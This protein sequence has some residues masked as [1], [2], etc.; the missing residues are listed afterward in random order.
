MNTLKYIFKTS[1]VIL[2]LIC[3]NA[4]GAEQKTILI[5]KEK[6]GTDAKFAAEPVYTMEFRDADLKDVLRALG[7]EN[8]LNIIISEK[9]SGKVTLSFNK[10]K[11]MDAIDTILRVNNLTYN[12]E[13]NIMMIVASPF[14]EGEEGLVTKKIPVDFSNA[15]EVSES[16]KNMLSS[17]GKITI[18][19]RTNT[20]IVKDVAENV[21]RIS[22]L[23]KSLDTKTPQVMI[24]AR[25]V[26]ARSG[27]SRE[28][29]VQWGSDY[30]GN[31]T[32]RGRTTGNYLLSGGGT[33]ASSTDTTAT[34]LT[35][36][37]GI[38]GTGFL[39]NLPA[40]VGLGSGGAIGFSLV[41][42]NLGLDLQLS[43]MEITGKGKILSN[44]R[45]LTL[46]NKEA[47]ISSGRDIPIKVLTTVSGVT[48]TEIRIINASLSL[49]VTPHITSDD[50]I[51]MNIK[52]EK[53]EP[54]WTRQVDNIPT[55]IKKNAITDMIIRNGD[56]VV[57]G[58][59]YTKE[60][61]DSVAGVPLLSK[62][63]ILGWLFKKQG[64]V[65]EQNE[66]LIFITPTV[67]KERA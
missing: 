36:G 64:I 55:I 28:L 38:A 54:D 25:I 5:E 13:G 45:I 33:K 9:V 37:I 12:R 4:Y 46:D 58:G 47:K 10:V 62:I 21:T 44:P 30:S 3:S 34:P 65:D 51:V 41:K 22:N 11:L 50:Q 57:I 1:I 8:N 61:Q 2:A 39:V 48:S 16:L 27:F 18:D 42:S 24:E 60:V 26:E 7:Q 67:I 63:P 56:T 29:G 43:A 31:I 14:G 6:T 53:A 40:A 52:A 49:T 32:S 17:K 35:S 19:Q 20:I 66:L 59:I 23:I 15:K